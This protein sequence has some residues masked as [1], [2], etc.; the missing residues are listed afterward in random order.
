MLPALRAAPYGAEDIA[1]A[2]SSLDFT[3]PAILDHQ[4]VEAAEPSSPAAT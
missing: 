3:N 1:V 4:W 2:F